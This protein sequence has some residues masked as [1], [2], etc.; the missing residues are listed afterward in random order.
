MYK[1]YPGD[2]IRRRIHSDITKFLSSLVIG[3]E[4]MNKGNHSLSGL[5]KVH[6]IKSKSVFFTCG[7]GYRMWAS[8]SHGILNTRQ[9]TVC[10]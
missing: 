7:N 6:S 1:D 4:I 10:I 2:M 5:L 3:G 8:S 9:K